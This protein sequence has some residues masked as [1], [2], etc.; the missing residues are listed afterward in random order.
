MVF[1]QAQRRLAS[2]REPDTMWYMR[3]IVSAALMSVVV[4]V[5]GLAVA[6]PAHAATYLPPAARQRVD[7]NASSR[8]VRSDA[9]GA[10]APGFNDA[11][12]SAGPRP[13]TPNAQARADAAST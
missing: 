4:T 13:D 3:R 12:G 2:R 9:A 6:A 11:A 8:F 1:R 5:A 7:L 10:P